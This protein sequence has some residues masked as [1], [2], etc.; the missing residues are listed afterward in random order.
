MHRRGHRH[1]A[2]DGREHGWHVQGPV[3]QVWDPICRRGL[4]LRSVGPAPLKLNPRRPW[5]SPPRWNLFT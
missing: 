3:S 1:E 2:W 5:P 4:T